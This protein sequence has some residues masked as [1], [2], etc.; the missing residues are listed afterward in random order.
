VKEWKMKFQRNGIQ[1]QTNVAL[2]RAKL[3]GSNEENHYILM[4]ATIY[5][6]DITIANTV[7]Q[8]IS[9]NNFIK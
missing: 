9:E 4:K 8:D 2:L 1:N 5:K 3:V 6:E 7:A